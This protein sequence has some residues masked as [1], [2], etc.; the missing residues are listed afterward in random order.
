MKITILSTLISLFTISY[1]NNL[2]I[3]IMHNNDM[4]ARFEE[5]SRNSGTC[6]SSKQERCVGGFARVAHVL[7]E[8]RSKAETGMGPKVLYLNAGDTYTGTV[9]FTVHKWRIVVDFLNALMP[10]VMVISLF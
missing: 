5:T 6:K 9:W 1:A 3:M 7:R 2:N 8:A 10:D 4:H